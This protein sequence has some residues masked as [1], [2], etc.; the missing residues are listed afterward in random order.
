MRFCVQRLRHRGR[1]LPK[2]EWQGRDPAVGDLRVEQLYDDDLL[3]HLRLARLVHPARS[4][5]PDALPALYDP[6]L[7][8]MSPQ[9]FTLTG[10][11]RIEG[12]D[13]AQSWL[14]APV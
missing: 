14:V 5:G 8:A 7:I 6:V 10:F 12:A 13:Y 3:R 11:E 2:R 1:V 9:A 4:A